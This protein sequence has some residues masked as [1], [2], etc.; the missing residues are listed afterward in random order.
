[1]ATEKEVADE[2]M[3]SPDSFK[4]VFEGS[5]MSVGTLTGPKDRHGFGTG[6]MPAHIKNEFEPDE[7]VYEYF[8]AVANLVKGD[9]ST[10][11]LPELISISLLN[12]QAV[13]SLDEFIS[14]YTSVK[15]ALKRQAA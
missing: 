3:K 15:N 9:M 12:N 10:L 5:G 13:I 7:A 14:R 11:S 2:I 4:A 1:M 6:E 8:L